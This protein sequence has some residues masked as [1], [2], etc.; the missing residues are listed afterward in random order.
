[1]SDLQV[2]TVIYM[3]AKYSDGETIKCQYIFIIMVIG[4]LSANDTTLKSKH[5]YVYQPSVD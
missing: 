5:Y 1:M 4:V 2:V 3:D